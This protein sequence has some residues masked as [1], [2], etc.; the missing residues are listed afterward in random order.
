MPATEATPTCSSAVEDDSNVRALL[1]SY[2]ITNAPLLR[3][4]TLYSWTTAEQIA[5]LR[6][7]PTLLTR[8]ADSNGEKGRA[9]DLIHEQATTDVVAELLD[10]PEYANKRFAWVSPWA[11]LLGWTGEDYGDRLLAMKLKPE[12]F[13]ATLVGSSP[14]EWSF[15]TADGTPI[16]A[17]EVLANPHRLAAVYFIDPR[18]SGYCGGTIAN[19]GSVFREFLVCNESMLESWSAFTPEL[20][21][22]LEQNQSALQAFQVTLTA[23][24]CQPWVEGP[25]HAAEVLQL[26]LSPRDELTTTLAYYFSALAFPNGLYE[27]TAATM[28]TLLDRLR[29]VPMNAEPL[30]HLYE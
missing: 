13:I 10:R 2:A 14:L 24:R 20:Q 3:E 29:A 28:G 18:D 9:A 21:A 16:G 7:D 25:C 23:S 27:P 6:D 30:V 17:E 1:D 11:T 8:S 15:S 12:A 26:W 22:E 19:A 5:E 4:R